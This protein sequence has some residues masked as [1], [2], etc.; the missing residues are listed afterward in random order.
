MM[1]TTQKRNLRLRFGQ[2][3][4]KKSMQILHKLN[5][6]T[7]SLAHLEDLISGGQNPQEERYMKSARLGGGVGSSGN[8]ATNFRTAGSKTGTSLVIASHNMLKSIPE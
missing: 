5:R 4:A 1:S 3:L 6:D 8:A 2:I 7:D